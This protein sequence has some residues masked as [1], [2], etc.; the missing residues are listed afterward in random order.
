MRQ[1]AQ[2][3]PELEAIKEQGWNV[4]F[5]ETVDPRGDF[6]N[7]R[8]VGA[9]EPNFD[10]LKPL[11]KSHRFATTTLPNNT[12]LTKAR[13]FAQKCDRCALCFS[14]NNWWCY[15]SFP[16]LV[17][18]F[19]KP[20]LFMNSA[21]SKYLRS[22]ERWKEQKRMLDRSSRYIWKETI[23]N[24]E[25]SYRLKKHPDRNKN[26]GVSKSNCWFHLDAKCWTPPLDPWTIRRISSSS[27]SEGLNFM[28]REGPL[29]EL[30]DDSRGCRGQST[31]AKTLFQQWTR[32]LCQTF[33]LTTHRHMLFTYKAF[34]GG[35]LIWTT[36]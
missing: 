26:L 21:R 24:T 16:I 12:A 23:R 36:L 28:G 10:T 20:H 18:L 15:G 4:F 27:S 3:L 32:H 34:L 35:G 29:V 9:L 6:A 7:D 1:C 8:H 13:S 31:N 33:F 5:A 14:G 17:V 22:F 11:T 19:Q 30:G 25:Y 2:K